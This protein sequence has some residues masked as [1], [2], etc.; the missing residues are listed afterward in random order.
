MRLHDI[1][2]EIELS[3]LID[4]VQFEYSQVVDDRIGFCQEN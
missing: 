2:V 1:G 4:F 3:G